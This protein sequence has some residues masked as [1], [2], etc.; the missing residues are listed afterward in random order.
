MN[1]CDANKA[2]ISLWSVTDKI[3][4]HV[5]DIH[6]LL[7]T[8]SFPVDGS[9][10]DDPPTYESSASK[11]LIDLLK[12]KVHRLEDLNKQRKLLYDQYLNKRNGCELVKNVRPE[13]KQQ[14][15]D[16]K[17]GFTNPYASTPKDAAIRILR[18]FVRSRRAALKANQALLD[19][20]QQGFTDLSNQ[21]FRLNDQGYSW[22]PTEKKKFYKEL[23]LMG[24]FSTQFTEDQVSLLRDGKILEENIL[25]VL[26]DTGE[27][28][29]KLM[30][31]V[32]DSYRHA[33]EIFVPTFF[34]LLLPIL[35]GLAK[36][37]SENM[38]QPL[39]GFVVAGILGLGKEF[40][41]AAEAYQDALQ[42]LAEFIVP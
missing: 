25:S 41:K 35:E 20:I 5:S 33:R 26:H 18:S 32:Q 1:D 11:H 27:Q 28:T 29:S 39:V 6:N 8:T 22:D 24:V 30:K 19:R 38:L 15:W 16:E 10:S 3:F 31:T 12:E 34:D 21:S 40:L 37:P 7:D 2:F 23:G 14:V 4:E 13:E 36:P 17:R 42:D 9:L